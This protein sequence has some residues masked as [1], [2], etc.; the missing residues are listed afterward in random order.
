MKSVI[1]V[2]LLEIMSAGAT[3]AQNS[4]GIGEF[5]GDVKQNLQSTGSDL[6]A[7][8]KIALML[9]AG[10]IA[11]KKFI[12]VMHNRSNW[13]EFAGMLLLLGGILLFINW[14]SGYLK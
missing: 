8:L 3:S 13:A 9:G 7:I 12:D 1:A 4:K 6:L 14:I 2:A 11:V 10:G 5:I